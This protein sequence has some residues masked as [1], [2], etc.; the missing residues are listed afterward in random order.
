ML[1]SF[2]RCSFFL[3]FQSGEVNFYNRHVF[4]CLISIK[5]KARV[6]KIKK[7]LPSAK[8]VPVRNRIQSILSHVCELFLLA[9]FDS[10]RKQGQQ[11][12]CNLPYAPEEAP[13]KH[14]L[15]L[16]FGKWWLSTLWINWNFLISI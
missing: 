12:L 3:H 15:S 10:H 11:I 1:I 5:S 13:A 6:A 9:G 4:I 16:N 14:H 7:R 2:P 8:S